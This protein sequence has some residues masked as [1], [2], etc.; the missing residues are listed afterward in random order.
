MLL[1]GRNES[2]DVVGKRTVFRRW[3][4]KGKGGFVDFLLIYLGVFRLCR[5]LRRNSANQSTVMLGNITTALAV[6]AD[7]EFWGEKKGRITILFRSPP[8]KPT[9]V[10]A[11]QRAGLSISIG[12][13]DNSIRDASILT[14]GWPALTRSPAKSRTRRTKD[15]GRKQK[16]T[17]CFGA[18]ASG[19]QDSTWHLAFQRHGKAFGRRTRYPGVSLRYCR[20]GVSFAVERGGRAAD[21]A[22]GIAIRQEKSRNLQ[23]YKPDCHLACLVMPCWW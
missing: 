5:S 14:R 15:G 3:N 13:L 16:Y 6:L 18:S 1:D 22:G 8:K 11:N 23:K 20:F 4:E 7:A 17:H 12:G 9:P 2:D 21:M 10:A 19:D